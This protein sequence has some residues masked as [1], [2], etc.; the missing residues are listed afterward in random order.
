MA[1][2]RIVI[3]LEIVRQHMQRHLGGVLLQRLQL[4]ERLAHPCFYGSNACSTVDRPH[5]RRDATVVLLHD[6]VDDDER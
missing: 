6:Q 3:P 5:D 4:I 2:K 1:K